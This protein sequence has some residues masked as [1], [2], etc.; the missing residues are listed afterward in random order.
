MMVD[1]DGFYQKNIFDGRENGVIKSIII[2]GKTPG[3]IRV[4]TEYKTIFNTILNFK[5]A[6]KKV[7][8]DAFEKYFVLFQFAG[9]GFGAVVVTESIEILTFSIM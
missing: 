5:Q 3:C 6:E 4:N 8:C 9:M 2:C 7:S 1:G